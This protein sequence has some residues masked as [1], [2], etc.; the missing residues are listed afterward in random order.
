MADRNFEKFH[1]LTKICVWVFS[2]MMITNPWSDFDNLKRRFQYGGTNF[3]KFKMADRNFEKFH[4]L[5]KVCIWGFSG[6]LITNP[7]S[8]FD[9]SK[10]RFQYDGT[11]FSKFKIVDPIWRKEISKNFQFLW[12][13]VYRGF[14][15]C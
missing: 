7:R 10:R 12:K 1:I 2:G 11:K 9:Y 15:G 3:S 6:M 8:D 4:I 13:F 14:R 5:I